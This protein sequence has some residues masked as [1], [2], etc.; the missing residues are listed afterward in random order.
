MPASFQSPPPR[1]GRRLLPHDLG[2]V[3]LI[4]IPA[5]AQGATPPWAFI[6]PNILFQSPPPRRGR[7]FTGMVRDVQVTDF[8]PRPRAGGDSRWPAR[9]GVELVFQSPPPRRG[10]LCAFVPAYTR[11]NIS[12]PA[13]AQGATVGVGNHLFLAPI[14]QSPPP[15]RG[16]LSTRYISSTKSHFNPRP[17]AGGDAGEIFN[18]EGL[19]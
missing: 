12:I 18:P 15:R 7:L 5:P 16:R 13:P 3:I 4:S 2:K 8:N 14:F 10:R 6:R 11:D 9:P 1:R 17:R 19:Y